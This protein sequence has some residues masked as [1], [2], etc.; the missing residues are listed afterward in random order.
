M[1]TGSAI[2]STGRGLGTCAC[3]LAWGLYEPRCP[4]SATTSLS[5]WEHSW[6]SLSVCR[7]LI[8]AS[9]W[10]LFGESSTIA[11]NSHMS[12]CFVST[13][14]VDRYFRSMWKA[15]RFRLTD[16]APVLIARR[17]WLSASRSNIQVRSS[18]W[19]SELFVKFSLV[20]KSRRHLLSSWTAAPQ[21]SCRKQHGKTRRLIEF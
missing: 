19:R 4:S 5:F 14:L 11:A 7:H 12:F 1:S 21:A 17:G 20:S 16:G 15:N 6:C 18:A 3:S 10:S 9:H 2:S 8:S 13:S